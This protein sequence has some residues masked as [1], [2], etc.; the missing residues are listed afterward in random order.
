VP[1]GQFGSVYA[2]V[3]KTRPTSDVTISLIT[4]GTTTASPSQLVFT[5]DNWNV[6]QRITIIARRPAAAAVAGVRVAGAPAA[7]IIHH[8][9]ISAD[10]TYSDA[11]LP[12]LQATIVTYGSQQSLTYLPLVQR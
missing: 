1:T 6:P 9:V 2:I 10:P 8:Q 4:D 11:S 5:P 12:D 7:S 3:L